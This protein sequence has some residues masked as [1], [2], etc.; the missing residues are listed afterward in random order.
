MCPSISD[1]LSGPRRRSGVPRGPG[2]FWSPTGACPLSQSLFTGGIRQVC[3]SALRKQHRVARCP[4]LWLT[5][6]AH[7]RRTRALTPPRRVSPS[8]S[9]GRL[10]SPPRRS[11]RDRGACT[12]ASAF[13]LGGQTALDYLMEIDRWG[14]KHIG[15]ASGGA[16]ACHMTKGVCT[17]PSQRQTG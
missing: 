2:G 1:A 7:S 11:M 13:V 17:S 8:L 16:Q 9:S 12:W 14:R 15:I 5:R 4:T 6:G 3:Q 10:A